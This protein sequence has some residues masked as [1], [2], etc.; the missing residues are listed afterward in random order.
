MFYCIIYC[1]VKIELVTLR[2]EKANTGIITNVGNYFN[3]LLSLLEYCHE[4]ELFCI[5]NYY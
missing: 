1:V 5:E 3:S 2:H 4:S